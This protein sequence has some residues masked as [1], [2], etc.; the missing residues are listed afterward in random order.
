VTAP[1]PEHAVILLAEDREDDIKIVRR[2]SQQAHLVNPLQV[3]RHGEE[4]IDYLS[5]NGKYANR[6]EYP[7][8]DLFLL[9]LKMPKIDGFQVLEWIRK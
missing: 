5:G 7:L 8:P 1:L 3:V 6:C 2:P 4:A 9:D